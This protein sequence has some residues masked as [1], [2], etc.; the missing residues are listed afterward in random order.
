MVLNANEKTDKGAF[1]IDDLVVMHCDELH[2]V[3]FAG[4]KEIDCFGIKSIRYLEYGEN[5][6]V[7]SKVRRPTFPELYD[8]P[9]LMVAEF[10][11][12]AYDNGSWD[13]AGFLKC[14]HSVFILMRWCELAGVEAKSIRKNV[15]RKRYEELSARIDP[16]YILAFLNSE[17]MRTLLAGVNRS[18]I[19]GRLQPDDLR[20]ISI[21]VP[22]D[23]NIVSSISALAQKASKIQKRLLPL[24]MAGW[25][26]DAGHVQAPALIPDDIS[27]LPF[28][29]AR[30]RWGLEITNGDIKVHG[31]QRS[32][33]RLFQG[34][35][36]AI[37]LSA[38]APDNAAEW[39]RRQFLSLLEGPTLG[40][41]EAS[42]LKIPETPE[43]AARSLAVLLEEEGDVRALLNEIAEIRE[44]ISEQLEGLFREINHPPVR[45]EKSSS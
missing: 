14:N 6:R 3:P 40:E 45:R 4:S 12:F 22:D 31:L 38:F 16:G 7:P 13:G 18:A 1:T 44:K 25:S 2:P 28:G 27:S 5:T 17:Q 15:P 9:K 39:L 32:E 33:R 20:Q 26:I 43:L 19:A 35:R 36:E 24:R 10:G 41:V 34:K 11:G 21:P 23:P 42:Q 8:R 30:V 37:R 29:R